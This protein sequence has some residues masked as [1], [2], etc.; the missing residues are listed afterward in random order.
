MMYPVV[1]GVSVAILFYLSWRI[2]EHLTTRSSLSHVPG[3]SRGSWWEGNFYQIFHKNAWQFHEDIMAK[4]GGIIKVHSHFGDEQLYVSDPLALHHIVV[5]DQYIYEET[6]AFITQNLIVF[7]KGL[8]STLGEH[9]R[10]QRKMLNPVFSMKHMR[11]LLP[12]FYPIAHQVRDVL[13]R[14]VR[15]GAEEIN[16]MQWMSRAALEYIGQGGMGYSFEALDDMKTNEYSSAVKMF[17]PTSFGLI[18]WRQ[19]IHHFMWISPSVRRTFVEWVPHPLVQRFR[20]IVDTMH[21][22]SVRIFEE[23]KAAIARG[24]DA[25][26]QQVGSGKDIM[27]VLLRANIQADDKDQLPEDELLGQ[28]GTFI[29]AGHDTTTSALCRI[30]HQLVLHPDVQSKL[31]AEVTQARRDYGDLDYDRLMSLSY[32]DAVC[33]ETLRFFPPIPLLSR[34]TRKDVTLPLLWPIKSTDGNQI[35]EIALKRNTNIIISI[36]AANRNK[37]IWGQDADVWRPE[38]WLTPMAESNSRAQLPGVYASMMTFM[39]GGRAC[40]GFK[41]A[42][43]EM[44]LMLTVMLESFEFSL[45]RDIY[46]NMTGLQSPVIKGS[47]DLTPQLPLKVQFV[48]A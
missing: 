26:L 18:F 12:V 3:P 25:V 41:F 39:G 5:K 28:M 35:R 31:R 27:S 4:F 36:I 22:T 32:L 9:H 33:R 43:M 29:A 47:D 44:K 40:I 11:D 15:S 37:T 16:V 48:K 6:S 34:T 30:L 21:R 13:A 17:V 24:D 46:W 14:Q 1:Q 8:L 23:K 42:E 19:F 7:G 2:F 45:T 10:K 20:S 38:R